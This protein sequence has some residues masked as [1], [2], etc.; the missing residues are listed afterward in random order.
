MNH[1]MNIGV[2]LRTVCKEAP[3]LSAATLLKT[4]SVAALLFSMALALAACGGDE[5]DPT[6]TSADVAPT[7]AAIAQSQ[8]ATGEAGEAVV[9]T[10]IESAPSPAPEAVTAPVPATASTD[11]INPT[12]DAANSTATASPPAPTPDGTAAVFVPLEVEM[13]PNCGIESDLDLAGYA[14]L[15]ARMGCPTDVASYDPVALNEYGPGPEFDRFMLWFSSESTI[16]VLLPDGSWQRYDDTWQEGDP[17]FTC[18]PLKGEP[19]SPPLPRRG[20]GKVWCEV[21][22]L[23]E[24]LGTIVREERL[25]QHTVTQPFPGGRLLACFEDATIRY[26]RI[27][28][29]GTWY[30]EIQ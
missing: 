11:S 28:D 18:N 8:N 29:D 15:E 2:R 30:V 16:Y 26:F 9:T 3:R 19:E 17:T 23:Q 5:P 21:E 27:M 24:T 25:C 20:F 22:G 7:G 12:P 6:S 14:D 13:T 1:V 10:T 4:I